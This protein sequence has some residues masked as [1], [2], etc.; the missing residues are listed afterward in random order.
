MVGH[1]RS[2][3]VSLST[4]THFCGWVPAI[5]GLCRLVAPSATG[6]R[7]LRLV[8][9]GGAETGLGLGELGSQASHGR[10]Y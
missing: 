10:P 7:A 8:K 6:G 3:R 2:L 1:G 5:A 4:L 9:H